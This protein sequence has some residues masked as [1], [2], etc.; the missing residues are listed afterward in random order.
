MENSVLSLNDRSSC[1]A[2]E[3]GLRLSA[4]LGRGC[5]KR[6]MILA[7][8]ANA[9]SAPE[10]AWSLVDAGFQ[11]VFFAKRGRPSA[12]RHSRHAKVYEI[13]APEENSARTASELSE[14][15]SLLDD[16]EGRHVLLPLDDS[17]VWLCDQVIFPGGWV[18]AGPR[19]RCAELAMDKGRQIEAAGEAGFNV[20]KSTLVSGPSEVPTD[21]CFPAI[22]RPAT[23]VVV[24]KGRLEKGGNWICADERELARAFDAWGNRGGQ[25]LLQPFMQGIGEGIFGLATDDGVV[26]LSSHRRLRMMNPHGSGSSACAAQPVP[27]EMRAPVER[28][29]RK[30]GWVGMFMIELLRDRSGRRW[31]IELNGRSWGSMALAR[32]QGLEYPAWSAQIALDSRYSAPPSRAVDGPIECRNL[33][34]EVMHLLFVLRG[35]K[36]RAIEAWPSFWGTVRELLSIPRRTTFYNWRRDDWKVFVADS[37]NSIREQVFKVKR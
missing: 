35:S 24:G 33:G 37:F 25:L 7:G 14:L 4:A 18:L 22:L 9:L 13:T 10:V 21:L 16:Q 19:G 29:I 11:V 23:A 15:M 34:R 26:Q 17:A 31:F 27:E 2:E 6:P 1:V 5:T 8:F 28:F 36:S 3:H 12:V 30:S 32:R 20:P